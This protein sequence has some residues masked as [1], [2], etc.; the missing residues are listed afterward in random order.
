MNET[1]GP[2]WMEPCPDEWNP[3]A[4]MHSHQDL[5]RRGIETRGLVHVLK[6]TPRGSH[7]NVHRAYC[8]LLLLDILP[9][10]QQARTDL[11]M[12]AHLSMEGV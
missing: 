7:Q 6:Q 11:V 5:Q 8:R 9:A 10:D 12:L 4:Q 1:L 3:R 2:R